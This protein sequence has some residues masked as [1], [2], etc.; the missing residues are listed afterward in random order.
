VE[1]RKWFDQSQPQTLQAAVVLC[2]LNAALSLLTLLLDRNIVSLFSLAL[3]VEGVAAYGIANSHRWAYYL[4]I[5]AAGLYCLLL[6]YALILVAG[7]FGLLLNLAFAVV[8][9]V[10]L[11]HPMS[12]SYQRTWFR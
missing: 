12:R 3:L 7:S 9:L 6:L 10:L 11:L 8:L 2:Y 5:A 1:T 4:G